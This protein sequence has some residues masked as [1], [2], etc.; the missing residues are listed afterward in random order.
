MEAFSENFKYLLFEKNDS[1][2][3][4]ARFYYLAWQPTLLDGGAIVRIYG[5]KG[6]WQRV[7]SPLPFSSLDAARPILDAIR[8][9]RLRH[10]Y[11]VVQQN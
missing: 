6:S 5:R 7:L 1:R 4:I 3:N 8:N 10:G 2:R 9:R 11:R